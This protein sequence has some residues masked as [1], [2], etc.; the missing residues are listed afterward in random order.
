MEKARK[1]ELISDLKEKF[2]NSGAAFIVG[3]RGI[4]VTTMSDLRAKLREV[5]VDFKVVRNTLARRAVDGNDAEV[6]KDHFNGPVAVAFCRNDVA[7][8]AKAITDFAKEEPKL[9]LILGSMG[10]KLVSADEILAISK[11]PSREVLLSQLVGLLNNIPAGLV[12]VLSA[13]PRK[14]VY[15]L[16]AIEGQKSN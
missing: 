13:V 6:L 5:E 2:E 1:V 3:Y 9:E 8:G 7:A 4:D 11:L 10:A 14:L 12:G 15:V 16:K